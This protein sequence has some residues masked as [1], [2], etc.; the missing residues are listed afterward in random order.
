MP[1]DKQNPWGAAPDFW[2]ISA[3]IPPRAAD[4]RAR[5]RASERVRAAASVPDARPDTEAVPIT[6]PVPGAEALH[7][8]VEEGVPARG[9]SAQKLPPRPSNGVLGQ[10]GRAQQAGAV[11]PQDTSSPLDGQGEKVLAAPTA[12]AAVHVMS[13]KR[14]V[15]AG[16]VPLPRREVMPDR[17]A[18]AAAPERVWRH[19]NGFLREVRIFAH[20]QPHSYY[21][22]FAAHAK[23]LKDFEGKEAPHVPF[24][25]YMPQYTQLTRAQLAYY[26][27]WR[28][29]FRRGVILP[30]D[31]SYLLLYLFEIINLGDAID[32]K[33][34]QENMQ[35]LWLCY[36]EHYPRLDAIVREWLCDYALIHGLSPLALPQDRQRQLVAEARLKEFYIGAGQGDPLCDAVLAFATNYDY[37]K[38]KFYRGDDAAL[39]D[40]VLRGAVMLALSQLMAKN[41]TGEMPLG[42]STVTRE[43]FSGAICTYAQKKRIEVDFLSFS[44]TYRLRYV[45]TDVLKYAENA[46]RSHLGVKSRLSI[47]EVPNE[48]RAALD[49]YFKTALPPKA[50]RT[51]TKKA[52]AAPDY[53]Q[54]YELPRTA[55]S[56]ERAA[57][58]ESASWQT[59]A[60]L[61]EAFDDGQDVTASPVTLPKT[62]KEPVTVFETAFSAPYASAEGAMAHTASEGGSVPPVTS[63]PAAACEAGDGAL[64]GALG[65]LAAFLPLADRGD[66]A[67]MRRLAEAHGLMLDAVAD[68]INTAAAEVLGDIILEESGGTWQIVEDYRADLQSEGII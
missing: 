40:R 11:P 43:S 39:F 25:S 15:M 41:A 4:G 16:D 68:R 52:A 44:H 38:S 29:S 57:Q 23:K 1:E 30:A 35:R 53:E 51:V 17:A 9:A 55:L 13:Q 12:G 65:D 32:P 14:A 66:T 19:E 28:R 34:G 47:Y 42:H 62:E 20:G 31:Y 56:L 58:I 46:L 2:D 5:G 22:A 21:A 3:L 67:G 59:T 8:P 49:A 63:A 33:T 48:L 24:F 6:V 26:F 18:P 54:R 61:M 10:E 7:H 64:V 50:A 37:R 36:R 60:R 27:W 45:L